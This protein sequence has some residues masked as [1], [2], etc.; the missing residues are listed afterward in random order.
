MGETAIVKIGTLFIFH[1]KRLSVLSRE[2]TF[3]TLEC[4]MP[5]GRPSSERTQLFTRVKQVRV[6]VELGGTFSQKTGAKNANKF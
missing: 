2:I 1:L 4:P 3:L 5:G 6:H